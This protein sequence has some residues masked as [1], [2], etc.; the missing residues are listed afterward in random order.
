[1]FRAFFLVCTVAAFQSRL[2]LRMNATLCLD[3][4]GATDRIPVKVTKCDPTLKSQLF[5]IDMATGNILLDPS[6]TCND[7]SPCCLENFF[8]NSATIWGCS[9]PSGKTWKYD[10]PKGSLTGESGSCLAASGEGRETV[11]VPCNSHDI[12]QVW[13]YI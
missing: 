4:A 11:M 8:P 2:L 10:N 7:G 9:D 3:D 13:G 6:V 12:N 5:T 1:M